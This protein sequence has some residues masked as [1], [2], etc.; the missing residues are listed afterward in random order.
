M[1]DRFSHNIEYC[2]MHLSHV[3]C[4]S[5]AYSSGVLRNCVLGMASHQS[6]HTGCQ[7]MSLC[8]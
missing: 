4:Y 2:L 8:P 3:H 6:P 7:A 1:L 5:I